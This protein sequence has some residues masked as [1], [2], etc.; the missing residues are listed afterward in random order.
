MPIHGE[1]LP[2]A[3]VK[4]LLGE[5]ILRPKKQGKKHTARLASV[6][7]RSENN[8]VAAAYLQGNA[9]AK[10]RADIILNVCEP[11][12]HGYAKDYVNLRDPKSVEKSTS[13]RHSSDTIHR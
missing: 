6:R 4:E 11:V 3:L 12:W 10:Q 8:C 13:T 1:A 9:D 2:P 7:A 5:M